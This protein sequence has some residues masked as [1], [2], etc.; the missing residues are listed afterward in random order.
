MYN[1]NKWLVT[2]WSASFFLKTK[3]DSRET[4]SEIISLQKRK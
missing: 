3:K 2:N 4:G 1:I